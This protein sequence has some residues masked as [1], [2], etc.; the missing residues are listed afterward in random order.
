MS[1]YYFQRQIEAI[2]EQIEA[3]EKTFWQTTRKLL[4][5]SYESKDEQLQDA[6]YAGKLAAIMRELRQSA[7]SLKEFR[8]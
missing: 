3:I 1:I 7:D 4:G 8:A 2:Q 6:V 5:D